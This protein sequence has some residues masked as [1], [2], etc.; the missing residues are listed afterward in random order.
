MSTNTVLTSIKACLNR[1]LGRKYPKMPLTE[2]FEG[3]ECP[4]SDLRNINFSS[5]G[6]KKVQSDAQSQSY[7]EII[8]LGYV[9]RPK[10]GKI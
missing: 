6:R 3:P 7:P 10:H 1:L 2:Y 8:D 5:K 4:R 9:F